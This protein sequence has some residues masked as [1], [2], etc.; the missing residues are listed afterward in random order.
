[1]FKKQIFFVW[2]SSKNDKAGNKLPAFDVSTNSWKIIQKIYDEVWQDWV[3]ATNLV[4]FTPLKDGKIRYPTKQEK[5]QGLEKLLEEMDFH[6]PKI[7]FL[8]WKEVSDF[9]F[10]KLQWEEISEW[11]VFKNWI[12]FIATQ[13]P[14]YIFVYKRKNIEEYVQKIVEKI[15]ALKK[16]LDV[17]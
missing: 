11:K 1:M 3:H 9:V 14:S 13:H 15:Y 7:V 12:L 8:F 17:L 6:Q 16:T 4:P 2:L 5:I 10:Q